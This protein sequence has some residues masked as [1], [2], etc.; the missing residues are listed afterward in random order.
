MIMG[1]RLN[2]AFKQVKTL[3]TWPCILTHYSWSKPLVVACNT[4][5][6]GIGV[7]LTYN[8]GDEEHLIAYASCSL[9]PA[10]K[11]YSQIDKEA[12]AEIYTKPV[13][14]AKYYNIWC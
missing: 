12:F 3:L 7:V 10:K 14:N 9:A 13:P 1:Y 8:L 6:Y 11:N 5:P 2:K 4:L